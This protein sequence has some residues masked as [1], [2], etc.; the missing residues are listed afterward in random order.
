MPLS[1]WWKE[2]AERLAWE[3]AWLDYEGY[4]H[5][6]I[7]RDEATGTLEL[8]VK[9]PAGDRVLNLQV[10]FPPFFP[11][12][13]CEVRCADVD[14]LHHQNPFN[15]ELCLLGRSTDLWDPATSLASFLKEQVPRVLEAGATDEAVLAGA[16]EEHQAEPAAAF[17]TFLPES[18]LLIDEAAETG[19]RSSGEFVAS[20]GTEKIE[21]TI[22]I[23]GV[24][25]SLDGISLWA[26]A[27][28]AMIHRTGSETQVSG[29]WF[30]LSAFPK[31]VDAAS[32]IAAAQSEYPEITRVGSGF[33]FGN[34]QCELLAFEVPSEIGHRKVGTEWVSVLRMTPRYGPRKKRIRKYSFVKLERFGRNLVY[35]RAPELHALANKTVAIAGIGCVGAPA[36]L[37]LA[38]AAIGELR[39]LDND[40]V[41]A[42]TVVRWPIG[43]PAIGSLKVLKLGQNIAGN[44]PLTKVSV[45][46]GRVGGVAASGGITLETMRKFVDGVD[47]ILDATAELGV[48]SILSQIAGELKIPLVCIASTNGG[49]GGTIV[50]FEPGR[51][52]CYDCFLRHVQ[53]GV[54]EPPPASDS[55]KVQPIGC[56][57][58]T[59]LAA[60]FD[61][62]EIALA[63][64]RTAVSIL[65]NGVQGSYPE[66][67]R[68]VA[69]LKLRD[70]DGRIIYPTWTTYTLQVHPDCKQ[71]H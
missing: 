30:K 17:L 52:G 50:S 55:S 61:T 2:N 62:G 14:L 67:P 9:F 56:A 13:R 22:C 29:R 25:S 63:G 15:K 23:R 35:Q 10:L 54:I 36:A 20:I 19:A 68:G 44:Y 41:E 71:V 21:K 6:E 1:P 69:I 33:E 42:G 47:L 26:S 24:I 49:W 58:P 28:E 37:E 34:E 31:G 57:E 4:E 45:V 48:N 39:M 65:S 16:I 3:Y 46:A 7:G 27:R 70:S 60:N 38:R 11:R 32:F 64:V 43:I 40:V 53:D 8:R 18:E 59:Y 51:S 5:E 66:L 12:A